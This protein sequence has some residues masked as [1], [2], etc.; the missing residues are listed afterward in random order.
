MEST[1]PTDSIDT[2]SYLSGAENGISIIEDTLT[3][4]V[5]FLF[6]GEHPYY[7]TLDWLT[8]EIEQVLAVLGDIE[9]YIDV[10]FVRVENQES[11]YFQ[12]AITDIATSAA[13]FDISGIRAIM[14]APDNDE[15][16]GY[17]LFNRSFSDWHENGEGGLEIGGLSYE[18]IIHEMGHGLGLGH[19]HDEGPSTRIQGFEETD[20]PQSNTA[21]FGLNQAVFTVMSYVDGWQDAPFGEPPRDGNGDQIGNYGYQG[22]LAPLDIAVLQAAYGANQT[23]GSG[24]TDYEL[25]DVNQVGSHYRAIHDVDGIDTIFYTGTLDIV[26][27]LQAASLQYQFGGGGFVSYVHGVHG[28]Y[29]IAASTMLENATGGSGNDH[30]TGNAF[31]NILIGNQGNDT[32]NGL[33]GSD[34]LFGGNGFDIIFGGEGTDYA[35]V[36]SSNP[37]DYIFSIN[38]DGSV[39]MSA[40]NTNE[41]VDILSDIEFIKFGYGSNEEFDTSV[42]DLIYEIN[43]DN[44]APT[45]LQFSHFGVYNSVDSGNQQNQ[46]GYSSDIIGDVNGDGYDDYIVAAGN[47]NSPDGDDY[48]T[49]TVMSGAFGTVIYQV[50]GP[51]PFTEY[52]TDIASISDIDGDGIDDIVVGAAFDDFY[53]ENSGTVFIYSGIDGQL[54]RTHNGERNNNFG[55]SVADAGDV[56]GDGVTDILIGAWA[57]SGG[58]GKAYVLS[59]ATGVELHEFSGIGQFG[60]DVAG[61][62]DIDGDGYADFAISTSTGA[63]TPQTSIFSGFDGELLHTIMVWEQSFGI[64]IANAGDVNNDGINDLIIGAPHDGN[65]NARVLSGQDWSILYTLV[66]DSNGDAFGISVDGIGDLDKD[67]FDD[68]IVGANRGGPEGNGYVKVFSGINGYEIATIEATGNLSGFGWDVSGGGDFNGD[69]WIDILISSPFNQV[70]GQGTATTIAYQTIEAPSVEFSNLVYEEPDGRQLVTTTFN[71]SDPDNAFIAGATVH[72]R[73]GFDSENDI[74]HFTNQNGISGLYDELTGVLTLSGIASIED[75]EIAIR[76]VEYENLFNSASVDSR[77]IIFGVNDGTAVSYLVGRNVEFII[78]N[79]I[80]GDSSDDD[81]FSGYGDDI[82]DGGAGNDL[83]EGGQGADQIDGGTGIDTAS[84]RTSEAAVSVSLTSGT[85]SGGDSEGDTLS[86]IENIIGS[87]FADNLWGNGL[88]NILEGGLGDDELN[89]EG[90]FDFASYRHSASSVQVSLAVQVNTVSKENNFVFANSVSDIFN[91]IEGLIGSEFSDNL[92]GDSN[93]NDLIGLGG[94][95][96]LIGG[97]GND[98]LYG[99]A[100][101]DRFIGGLGADL[102]DGGE[103]FDTVDYSTATTGVALSFLM[104]GTAGEANGDSFVSIERIYGSNFNDT[105]TG[106]DANEFFYGED[107]NDTINAGGGIDRIYG[108]DGDDIQR[109]QEGNDQLYGSAGADQLNGGTGFDIAN[110]RAATA[111]ITVNLATGGTGGDADGDTYFGLEAIYGSDFNDSMTGSGGTNELRGFDGDDVLDGSDGNDRLFGGNGADSLIGGTGIDIAMYTVATA[112]VTLDLAAGGTGGEAAGDSFS[113]IEWVFGSDFNDDITGDSGANRLAGNDGNDTLNGAGGNDRLLGGEGND[114]IHGGDGVDTIFGQVG[115]DIMSGGAG[116]DFFF[117]D[118]GAD[119]HDGGADF[120][121]VSYL[122]S[123][124]GVTVNMQTGGTGGDAAGDSYVSIERIFGSS[125]DDNLTGSDGNDT[126]IGNGGNDVL[127]GGLG[128]DSLNGGAGVDRFAYNTTQ[129]AADVIQGFTVNEIIEIMGG[130]PAFD[131]FAELMAVATDAGANTIFN[132]GS[133]NTLTIV[134]QNIADLDIDNFTFTPPMAEPLLDNETAFMFEP[135]IN[136]AL[137]M[138]TLH[139]DFTFMIGDFFT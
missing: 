127:T 56:D 131:S 103:G 53:G 76:S 74:L 105:V 21:D 24:D 2:G 34:V 93:N 102:L 106:S 78:N 136:E 138:A 111:A 23:T 51:R 120:D 113:G 123:S 107:G 59:G 57:A 55:Y 87:N 19:T 46:F 126:L 83:I 10:D 36:L 6:A 101:A 114:T 45:L 117:G 89:G 135:D 33:A 12:L 82:I 3:I 14:N 50:Y 69:E 16:V 15:G 86:N 125:H 65:G 67:G 58:N 17:G 61:L 132:F 63:V 80:N 60:S 13:T 32:L 28:G 41:N 35:A 70:D 98:R 54:I 99:D 134:G 72:V 129:D 44:A 30:L 1:T 109:G 5:Y 122:A 71:I 4:G 81:I 92:T 29:T 18:T 97:A 90:G 79:Q 49:L 130:D 121:T 48:G 115:D 20:D 31:N 88:D 40:L 124:I 128:N 7:A 38:L 91:S 116:N 110:Y 43:P 42:T 37:E 8:Y 118:S 26:V 25:L 47:G 39:R 22:T 27:N 75:Y 100:G 62:G 137:L 108:G 52:G 84:Y 112:G 133:G 66:G 95:D 73:E 9:S 96:F 64:S 68:L 119:S 85:G 94:S 104:G 11:A 77:R 139:E